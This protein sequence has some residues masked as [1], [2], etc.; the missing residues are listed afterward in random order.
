QPCEIGVHVLQGSL[1]GMLRN[2]MANGQ[3][4]GIELMAL[5]RA[6]VYRFDI[7]DHCFRMRHP[8]FINGLARCEKLVGQ[9]REVGPKDGHRSFNGHM[10][11]HRH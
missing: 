2:R 9:M 10:P 4:L 5:P 1:L 8:Q 3:K 6:H 7:G 11:D